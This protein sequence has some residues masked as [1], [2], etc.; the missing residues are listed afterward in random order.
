MPPIAAL[1]WVRA[2]PQGGVNPRSSMPCPKRWVR[3]LCTSG[4]G[5]GG[6]ADSQRR[7]W[8]TPTARPLMPSFGAVLVMASAKACWELYPA[9]RRAALSLVLPAGRDMDL[10]RDELSLESDTQ[11]PHSGAK[12]SIERQQSPVQVL[13]MTCQSPRTGPSPASIMSSRHCGATSRHAPRCTTGCRDGRRGW[14]HCARL[15]RAP[16]GRPTQNSPVGRL[17]RTHGVVPAH[18]TQREDQPCLKPGERRRTT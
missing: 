2:L 15:R 10:L 11:C 16:N 18:P 5:Q 17:R 4:C 6:V 8:R 14:R 12:S 9:A 13:L 3:T 7:T 1:G